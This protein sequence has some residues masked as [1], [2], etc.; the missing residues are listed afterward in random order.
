LTKFAEIYRKTTQ[1]IEEGIQNNF[2]PNF[3][4]FNQYDNKEDDKIIKK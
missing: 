4:Q 2:K 1:V 3:N